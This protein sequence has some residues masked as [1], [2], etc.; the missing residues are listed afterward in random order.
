M[1]KIIKTYG[2]LLVSSTANTLS[3]TSNTINGGILLGNIDASFIGTGDSLTN[4]SNFV[5]NTEFIYLSGLTGHVQTQINEKSSSSLSYLTTSSSPNLTNSKIISADTNIKFVTTS[6]GLTINQWIGALEFG[7]ISVS[8]SGDSSYSVNN[9]TLSGWNDLYPNRALQIKINPLC[10]LKLTGLVGGSDGRMVTITNVGNFLIIIENL[11]QSSNSDNNFLLHNKSSYF[12]GKNSSINFLYNNNLKKWVQNLSYPNNKFL[13]YDDFTKSYFS[14]ITTTSLYSGLTS[15]STLS[16]IIYSGGTQ[17]GA[18]FVPGFRTFSGCA[19]GAVELYKNFQNN[20]TN[21]TSSISIGFRDN[22]KGF[23]SKT[24]YSMTIISK[25]TSIK[26]VPPFLGPLDNWAL[27]LGTK[28]V[29]ILTNYSATTN[30]NTT[31]P[32]FNGGTFWLFDYSGN[33]QYARF[34]VQDTSNSTIVRNSTF[35]LLDV[36]GNTF[37]TFG[38]YSLTPSGSSLGSSTFFWCVNSG[39]SEN[40]IIEPPI[41]HTGGTINGYP[42]LT[43]YGAYNYSGNSNFNNVSK[44][45]V[46][47]FGFDFK[48]I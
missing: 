11:S 6:T 33:P 27:T 18:T 35:N 8:T 22:Y 45:V 3:F 46:D 40:Y 4:K 9:L 48:K 19:T 32:N 38:V 47:N 25:F 31:F 37:K 21:S 28:N 44:I 39:N 30:S 17:P 12:L 13:I 43:F 5:T 10:V 2:N 23:Q 29:N 20:S 36:T 24:G 7:S 15:A 1:S 26:N 42:S 41:F 34:A 16:T 14:D